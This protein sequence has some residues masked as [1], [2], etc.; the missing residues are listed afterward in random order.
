M[1]LRKGIRNTFIAV[2]CFYSNSL[3]AQFNEET[4]KNAITQNLYFSFTDSK[5]WKQVQ[6]FYT[7]NNYHP[8]WVNKE[9]IVTRNV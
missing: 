5:Q 8:A 4:L 1:I 9:N 6:S 7:S 2:F 3:N